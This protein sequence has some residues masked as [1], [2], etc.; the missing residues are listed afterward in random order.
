MH[1]TGNNERRCK[2]QPVFALSISISVTVQRKSASLSSLNWNQCPI[3]P[4]YA[5]NDTYGHYIGD[6]LLQDVARRLLGCIREIDT[7]ARLGGD[8]FAV[9]LH[10]IH[11]TEINVICQRIIDRMRTPYNCEGKELT[12]SASIGIAL[13]PEHGGDE[14]SLLKNA[15]AAMYR[16]KEK[17]KNQFDYFSAG[18]T[19]PVKDSLSAAS[20][21]PPASDEQTE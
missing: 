18:G 15:D 2:K 20:P 17:G 9:I 12:I 21:A 16:A 6:L 7:A 4:E 11:S 8:E 3:Q 5:I 19:A 14:C 10:H 13:F 1:R